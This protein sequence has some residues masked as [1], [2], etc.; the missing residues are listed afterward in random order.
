MKKIFRMAA[1]MLALGSM[2][3][4]FTSCGEDDE[5][6]GVN[7]GGETEVLATTVNF[8]ALKAYAQPNGKI[9]IEGSITANGKIKKFELQDLDGKTIV[10]LSD[11][12]TKEKDENGK[13]SFTMTVKSTAVPVQEMYL[14]AKVKDGETGKKSEKIGETYKFDCGAGAKSSLGSYVSLVNNKS[15]KQSEVKTMTDK[16]IDLVCLAD[17]TF[18]VPSAAEYQYD[19]FGT[20]AVFDANG[21]AVDAAASGTVITSTGCIAT[22]SAKQSEISSATEYELEISGVVINS[23][24]SLTIDVSQVTLH[25]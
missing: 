6:N 25:K 1:F 22:F 19:C 24:G 11:V 18:Q 7:G 21:T 17:K 14:V 12:Q 15:Y 9:L 3:A 8:D 2:T 23:K 16:V 20:S 4:G 13:K 10:D 5:E